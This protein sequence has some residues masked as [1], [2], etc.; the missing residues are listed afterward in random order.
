MVTKQVWL[1]LIQAIILK[2][3][4]HIKHIITQTHIWHTQRQTDRQTSISC[5]YSVHWEDH[6]IRVIHIYSFCFDYA[7]SEKRWHISVVAVQFYEC[8]TDTSF[9]P[10]TV[11]PLLGAFLSFLDNSSYQVLHLQQRLLPGDYLFRYLV[12]RRSLCFARA[13]SDKKPQSYLAP[14]L[15]GAYNSFRE[16]K[17]VLF[18]RKI[19]IYLT[20]AWGTT[21]VRN[22]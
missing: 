5:R 15:F 12:W 9:P 19:V 13:P 1:L 21:N 4:K 17:L 10:V 7:I 11:L 22:N 20:M 3:Y 8:E 18:S 2:A 6:S 14:A 16:S